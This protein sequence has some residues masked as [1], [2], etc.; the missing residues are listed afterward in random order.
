[1]ELSSETTGLGLL[2]VTWYASLLFC[3]DDY[4]SSIYRAQGQCFVSPIFRAQGAGGLS[5]ALYT[6]ARD[7]NAQNRKWK[8]PCKT[9]QPTIY[10]MKQMMEE[11]R[12]ERGIAVCHFCCEKWMVSV[13]AVSSYQAELDP[14]CE[15]AS[16]HAF[17]CAR[18]RA[19]DCYARV[20]C[21][22]AYA[23]TL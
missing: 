19:H 13:I 12:H 14:P 5:H 10:Y 8:Q 3:S 23:C 16:V 15:C 17:M 7:T 6:L 2:V 20:F 21:R 11:M 4:V 22:R 18:T 9:M 1:M